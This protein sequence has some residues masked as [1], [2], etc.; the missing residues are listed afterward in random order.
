MNTMNIHICP[1]KAEDFYE[2]LRVGLDPQPLVLDHLL[3]SLDIWPSRTVKHEQ[4]V[5]RQPQEEAQL[6]HENPELRA[7][8]QLAMDSTLEHDAATLIQPDTVTLSLMNTAFVYTGRHFNIH[9]PNIDS[10]AE[11]LVLA[12]LVALPKRFPDDKVHQ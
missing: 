10:E 2:F 3:S 12:D 1:C 7:F 6:V 8:S 4:N 5:H 11:E 9:T